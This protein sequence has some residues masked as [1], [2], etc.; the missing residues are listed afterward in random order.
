[1][2]KIIA[3]LSATSKLMA[4]FSLSTFLSSRVHFL[5]N[6]R[7]WLEFEMKMMGIVTMTIFGK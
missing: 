7:I 3:T 2:G 5:F 4:H 1:M 6:L